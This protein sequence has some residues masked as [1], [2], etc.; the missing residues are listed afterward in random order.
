MNRF[1]HFFPNTQTVTNFRVLNHTGFIKPNGY[2]PKIFGN[3]SFHFVNVF[4]YTA[5]VVIISVIT[6]HFSNQKDCEIM[7]K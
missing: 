5:Q 6:R 2:H 7:K 4:P 1:P 3:Y